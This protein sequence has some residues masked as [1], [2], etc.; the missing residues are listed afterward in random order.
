MLHADEQQLSCGTADIENWQGVQT[1]PERQ[2]DEFA[3]EFLL[4]A[5]ELQK[6]IGSQWPS[7]QLVIALSEL[8]GASLTATARKY[9]DVAQQKGA[10]VWS[11]E[12]KIR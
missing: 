4:P 11:V 9:C 2:A 6:Q 7:F 5:G 12:G 10:M 3:S 1:N 8:F